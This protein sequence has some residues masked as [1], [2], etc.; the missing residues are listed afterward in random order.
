MPLESIIHEL[1]WFLACSTKIGYPKEHGVS[2]GDELADANGELGRSTA[3]SG[4]A[5][6]PRMARTS[7]R[8]ARC[9]SRSARSG[10]PPDDHLGLERRR[11]AED[12]AAPCHALFQFYMA[13]DKLSC[14]LY[15]R[16]VDIFPGVPFN[17]A[18]YA[19]LIH[20]MAQQAELQPGDFI[21]TGGDCH[22]YSNHLEQVE[23]SLPKPSST[24]S[25]TRC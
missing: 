18:S 9:W 21:W 15:Q 4:A 11:R 17:I 22:L 2:I 3:T 20:M 14:Q 7:T 6:R 5:G 25:R 10:L 19:L 23:R 8:S 24:A 13:D 1:I 16:S 12:E